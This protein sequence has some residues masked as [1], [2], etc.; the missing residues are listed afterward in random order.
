MSLTTVIPLTFKR[1]G[2]RRIA[3]TGA[4]IHDT[5][6]LVALGRGFYWQQLLDQ[7]VVKSG[8]DISRREGLHYATVNKLIRLTLLAPDLIERLLD[9]TQPCRLN[10][11]WFQHHHLPVGWTEQRALFDSFE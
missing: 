9:G 2:V 8:S 1:R 3:D 10:L 11:T 5:H 7:G 6:F 4:P